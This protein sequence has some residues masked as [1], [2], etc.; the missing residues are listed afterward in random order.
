MP[1]PSF[2]LPLALEKRTLCAISISMLDGEERE[3]KKESKP[4]QRKWRNIQRMTLK[5][6]HPSIYPSLTLPYVSFFHLFHLFFSFSLSVCLSLSLSFSLSLCRGVFK[7][8]GGTL[9]HENCQ[10]R[11]QCFVPSSVRCYFIR[12]VSRFYRFTFCFLFWF[13][14]LR[15]GSV[16][17]AIHLPN[18]QQNWKKQK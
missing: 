15:R 6:L 18:N 16:E 17:F 3:K 13:Q 1:P 2:P 14:R 12:F 10:L 9:Q 7:R 5:P 11:G 8:R 4:E